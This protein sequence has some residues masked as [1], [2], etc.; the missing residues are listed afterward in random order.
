MVHPRNLVLGNFIC[1][2]IQ[3]ASTQEI[4]RAYRKLSLITHPDRNKAEDAEIQ[5]RQLVAVYE[6]LKDEIKREK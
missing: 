1:F 6:T 2:L 4:K 5:F 3:D